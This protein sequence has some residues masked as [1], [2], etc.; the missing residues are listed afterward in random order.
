M[1]VHKIRFVEKNSSK[2]LMNDSDVAVIDI[3]VES[4][5]ALSDSSFFHIL[6]KQSKVPYVKNKIHRERDKYSIHFL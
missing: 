2:N 5:F 1:I 6:Q 4:H 3:Y